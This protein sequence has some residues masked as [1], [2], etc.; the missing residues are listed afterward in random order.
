MFVHLL[1]QAVGQHPVLLLGMEEQALDV[2]REPVF[3]VSGPFVRADQ[4]TALHFRITE[5]HDLMAKQR[6][7]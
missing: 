1:V 4:D 3:L 2:E 5:K 6:R 7:K